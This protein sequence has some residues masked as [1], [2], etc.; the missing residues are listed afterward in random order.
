MKEE[1]IVKSE[2][3]TMKNKKNLLL[4]VLFL[5]L[6][7]H[8]MY[9]GRVTATVENDRLHYEG[10]VYEEVSE[11]VEVKPEQCLGS[12]SYGPDQVHRFYAVKDQ[13]Q[14]VYVNLGWEQKLYKAEGPVSG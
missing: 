11:A 10:L 8:Q 6:M 3:E 4:L 7:G 13:P 2:E 1:V 5:A 12:V 9:F 14:Y